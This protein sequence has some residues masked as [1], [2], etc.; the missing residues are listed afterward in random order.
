MTRRGYVAVAAAALVSL[1][2]A[3]GTAAAEPGP[4]MASH[5]ADTVGYGPILG[6]GPAAWVTYGMLT[7]TDLAPQG[8]NDWSCRPTAA[9]PRP[10]VLLHGSWNSSMGSFS[11]LSPQLAQAGYC[12]FAL[13][14]GRPDVAGAGLVQ[15]WIG[16]V[17]PIDQSA[18]QLA[19]FVERVRGATGAEQVDM[20]GHS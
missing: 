4:E 15:P 18:R 14:Y 3:S 6:N 1:G 2:S 7:G 12:V 10:I 19:D 13:N 16:A 8:S 5:A 11:R 20:I 17:G 9:H